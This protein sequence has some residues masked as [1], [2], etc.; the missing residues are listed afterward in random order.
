MQMWALLMGGAD[1]RLAFHIIVQPA[2]AA[3]L[4]IRTGLRDKRTGCRPLT[5]TIATDHARRNLIHRSWK[6][7]AILFAAAVIIDLVYALVVF[8]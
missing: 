8:L 5:G 4:A 7:V 2:I 1:G 3:L 6:D